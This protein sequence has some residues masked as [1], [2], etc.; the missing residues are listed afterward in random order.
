MK[1]FLHLLAVVTLMACTGLIGA[2]LSLLYT[3]YLLN[4]IVAAEEIQADVAQCQAYA[5]PLAK[6]VQHYSAANELLLER[7]KAAAKV[8]AGLQEESTRLKASLREAVENLKTLT[9]QNNELMEKN[10]TYMLRISELET[11]V[12]DLRAALKAVQPDPQ[13]AD[14]S[15]K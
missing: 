13:P 3:D 6:S 7:E 4:D 15:A 11:T 10:E 5:E 12:S 8:V 2:G 1:S 14:N 9:E